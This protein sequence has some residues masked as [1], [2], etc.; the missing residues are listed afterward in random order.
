MSDTREIKSLLC[1]DFGTKRIGVAVGQTIT[2]TATP[3]QTITNKNNRPD[4]NNIEQLIDEWQPDALVVGLPL[5]MMDEVQEMTI[6]SEKFMRQ[7]H[8]RFH[9]PVYSIDERLSSFEA[10]QRTGKTTDIDPVAA[11]AI[12]ETW[13]AENYET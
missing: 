11:Q 8:G 1:F 13:L 7:L 9:L 5:N 12:L 10:T 4:W 2:Q 6:A 3:L